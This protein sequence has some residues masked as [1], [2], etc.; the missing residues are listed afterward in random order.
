MIKPVQASDHVFILAC[1]SL[2]AHI[3][4]TEPIWRDYEL[5]SSPTNDFLGSFIVICSYSAHLPGEYFV[6]IYSWSSS[7]LPT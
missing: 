6:T 7:G 2:V 5:F 3:N 1:H 4:R